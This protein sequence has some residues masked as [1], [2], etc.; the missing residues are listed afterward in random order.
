MIIIFPEVEE[1][2]KSTKQIL[3]ERTKPP[4]NEQGKAKNEMNLRAV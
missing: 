1:K 3:L 2:P 4:K